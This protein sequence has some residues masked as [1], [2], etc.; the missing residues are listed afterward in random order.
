MIL[1]GFVVGFFFILCILN[2][3]KL[4][5][6]ELNRLGV[7]FGNIVEFVLLCLCK[8]VWF[9]RFEKLM[10]ELGVLIGSICFL[11]KLKL[12]DK[13]G[14]WV[15]VLKRFSVDVVEVFLFRFMKFGMFFSEVL[16]F[17]VFVWFVG[18][19]LLRNL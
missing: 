18:S 1:V 16:F 6:I 7:V 14:F 3:V 15:V 8:K 11:N 2:D 10:D 12:R 13:W 19:W 4:G 9:L 5:V 17:I